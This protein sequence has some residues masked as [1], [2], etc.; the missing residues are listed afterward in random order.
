M[1]WPHIASGFCR[2]HVLSLRCIML[3]RRRQ[4]IERGSEEKLAKALNVDIKLI[5]I[6]RT[7]LDGV[8]PEVAEMLK[9]KSVDTQ[10]F[11]LFR[12]GRAGA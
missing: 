11:A 5:K 4:A 8:C 10:V 7:L 3:P 2:P 9:D 6:K 12:Q 1:L